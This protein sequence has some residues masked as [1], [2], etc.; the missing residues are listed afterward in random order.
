MPGTEYSISGNNFFFSEVGPW[1]DHASKL[2]YGEE[3]SPALNHPCELVKRQREE[4]ARLSTHT[5]THHAYLLK[6][7]R[8]SIRG[9]GPIALTI[10]SCLTPL[11]KGHWVHQSCPTIVFPF[12]LLK[13]M[14][15]NKCLMLLIVLIFLYRRAQMVMDTCLKTTGRSV[16]LYVFFFFFYSIT[17][18]LNL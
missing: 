11:A 5:Q 17:F 4:K 15:L 10:A 1:T 14:F 9:S 18:L 8:P 16:L 6:V 12:F 3:R 7:E 2:S 13:K